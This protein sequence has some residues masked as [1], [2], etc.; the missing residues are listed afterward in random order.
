MV[1]TLLKEKRTSAL[2]ELGLWW[3]KN[4]GCGYC[5]DR[6][7]MTCCLV[8]GGFHPAQVQKVLWDGKKDGRL[9]QLLQRGRQRIVEAMFSNPSG[10]LFSD[11]IAVKEEN[12]PGS[13]SWVQEV[14]DGKSLD[15]RAVRLLAERY[16]TNVQVI[17]QMVDGDKYELMDADGLTTPLME[18]GRILWTLGCHFEAVVTKV[19]FER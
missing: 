10:T 14:T 13:A 16:K 19:S 5:G 6:S 7:V 8:A 17:Q 11:V 4:F 9:I 2:R 1:L 3:L 15:F 12:L 18:N